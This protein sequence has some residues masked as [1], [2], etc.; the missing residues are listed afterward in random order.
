MQY[1]QA[2]DRKIEMFLQFATLLSL[3]HSMDPQT[4]T[5]N[6]KLNSAFSE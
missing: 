4:I 2:A 6:Q 3:G 1:S 5:A